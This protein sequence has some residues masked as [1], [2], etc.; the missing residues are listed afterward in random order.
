MSCVSSERLENV[1]LKADH[2]QHA[3]EQVHTGVGGGVHVT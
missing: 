1:C 3:Y 2:M